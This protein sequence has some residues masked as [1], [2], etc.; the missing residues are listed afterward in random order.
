ML[1][2]AHGTAHPERRHR[3]RAAAGTVVVGAVCAV[4]FANAPALARPAAPAEPAKEPLPLER[5][6]DN[7]AVSDDARPREADFDGAGGSFSAQDLA[8]AGWTPGKELP[9]DG[10]A[11]RWPRSAPGTP[12]NVR[13]AGQTVRL[14]GRGDALTFL[15][16]G[17]AAA[18]PGGDVSGTGTVRYLDGS[19]S[20][21]RLTAPDWRRGPLT[22]KAV[23]L[24]HLNTPGGRR[25][26]TTRLHAVTVP[27]ARGRE[28]ESVV[29]PQAPRA[30]TGLHVFSMALRAPTNEWTGSWAAPTSGYTAVGPW[31]DRTLRLVVHGSAGGP[32]TRIRLENTFAAE[33]VRI[34]H[35]TVAVQGKGATAAA[36][37]RTL[38]FGGK[39]AAVLPAGTQRFSDPLGFTVPPD[40]SLLVSIHLPG[41]V[42]ALPVH[43]YTNQRSYLTADG[44]GDRTADRDAG[45]YTGTL[46]T[47]PLLTGV[48]VGGGPGSVVAL[49]DSITDGERST[50]DANGRWPDLLSRRLRAQH[51]VPAYGVLN[52]GISGN[53][54]VDDRYQGSGPST[55]LSGV[56]AGHRLER[57]V[58]AQSQARTVIVFEGV[59]D[60]RAGTTATQVIAALRSIAE[61]AHERGLRVIAATIAPCGGFYDCTATADAQRTAINR[62]IRQNGGVYDAV[63]DFD[64]AV[65]DPQHPERMLPR[66]DGGD[67]L[68]PNDAGMKAFADAVDLRRLV[69]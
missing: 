69:G 41:T 32:R 13:A 23:G 14:R 16:A 61:R 47:W 4:A 64:A 42:R 60:I 33:P 54:V 9:I 55:T 53:R 44:G 39:Q 31:K 19:R 27:V 59:N 21:Y 29:L 22:T 17:S 46:A 56:S 8:A 37:P 5:L 11:L 24:P 67:H 2:T 65:R 18:G 36:A 52:S 50:P 7:K 20:T 6:F 66:F 40:T 45:A 3:R 26:E 68:H 35:A 15:V 51:T 63:F 62:H 25:T 57:D 58:L 38:T 12:D 48:D 10:A 43:N 1:R 30:A 49:G 34:G 28:V